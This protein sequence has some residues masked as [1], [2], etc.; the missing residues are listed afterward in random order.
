MMSGPRSDTPAEPSTAR[1]D[2]RYRTALLRPRIPRLLTKTGLRDDRQRRKS[3]PPTGSST[4]RRDVP[5]G[6]VGALITRASF[7]E[8]RR[9]TTPRFDVKC[10]SGPFR[11]TL[12]D[13]T[14][15]AESLAG[16]GKAMGKKVLP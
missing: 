1:I 7:Q 2:P 11:K 4:A 9:R 15:L 10:G 3:S 6:R 14:K 13:A 5:N 12:D 16:T 8:G